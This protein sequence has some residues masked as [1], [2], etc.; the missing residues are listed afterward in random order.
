[1]NKAKEN[2]N[3]K[4]KTISKVNEENNDKSTNNNL[5]NE[6]N[7][8]NQ[9]NINDNLSDNN[10]TFNKENKNLNK[11]K[12]N[13]DIE[14]D[15]DDRK[16]FEFNAHFKYQELVEA[17]NALQSKKNESTS[18]T[19]NANINNN[20]NS[21]KNSNQTNKINNCLLNQNQISNSKGLSRNIQMNNY[22]EYLQHIE[23]NKEN[24]IVLTSIADTIKKN[25]TSFL[26]QT[27]LLKKKN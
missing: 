23:E 25:K 1:M 10:I 8:K 21:I 5:Q 24:N 2:I 13:D 27:E 20:K 9:N 16:Y 18:N 22:I 19:S 3:L 4:K 6:E 17:L 7:K 14:N 15:E 12:I 11:H 26:P